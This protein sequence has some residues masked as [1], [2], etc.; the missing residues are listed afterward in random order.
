MGQY[1]LNK[2]GWLCSDILEAT[3]ML[4]KQCGLNSK[5]SLL[6][7]EQ[8]K[9]NIMEHKAITIIL[10]KGSS[11]TIFSSTKLL[12]IINSIMCKIQNG[13]GIVNN[14]GILNH[15]SMVGLQIM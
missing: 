14:G 12:I 7:D 8:Y 6:P 10:I 5:S 3:L 13:K 9:I 1:L 4:Y 15:W 2:L 11:S